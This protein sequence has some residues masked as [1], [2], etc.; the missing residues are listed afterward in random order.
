MILKGETVKKSPFQ[1][2][3]RLVATNPFAQFPFPALPG[4]V[5]VSPAGRNK[6]YDLSPALGEAPL[7]SLAAKVHYFGEFSAAIKPEASPLIAGVTCKIDSY[8]RYLRLF[9]FCEQIK[10]LN[11][12]ESEVLQ[13]AVENLEKLTNAVVETDD[14]AFPNGRNWDGAIRISI[15][16]AIFRFKVAIKENVLPSSLTRLTNKLSDKESILIAKYISSNARELLEQRQINYLDVAGNCHIRHDK[17][18][19]W[20]IKGQSG[21]EAGGEIKHRAFHKNG[22]KLIGA[23]LLNNSL[24]N[25]P[26]RAIAQAANISVGTVGDI[27]NDLQASGFLLQVNDRQ[28]TLYDKPKLLEQW[29]MAYNQRLKPKLWKGKYRFGNQ[30]LQALDTGHVAFWGG[31]SAAALLTGHL[32]PGSLTLY[33]DLDRKSLIKDFKLAPD[34]MQGNVEVY[35]LFWKAE[36]EAFVLPELK[37]VHPLLVYADLIGSG[38][39]RNFETAQKIYEQYLKNIIE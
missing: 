23:L 38:N 11:M 2:P 21:L 31:E 30:N 20:H 15:G 8:V 39:D 24:L 32:Q 5:P 16:A 33:T 36:Y 14:R 7:M 6:G 28:M 17:G 19:F 12:V 34:P 25:E 3:K 29:V 22:I 27:L 26:Y 4:Q 1:G 13:N 9:T 37:T 35:S 10:L 18:L